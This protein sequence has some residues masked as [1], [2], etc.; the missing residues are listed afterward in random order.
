VNQVLTF[1]HGAV[2]AEAI[3][4]A[5]RTGLDLEELGRVLARSFGQSRMLERSLAR[6]LAGDLEAGA[7]LK[8]YGKDLGLIDRAAAGAGARLPL[9]VAAEGVLAEARARGLAEKDIAALV[10][11]FRGG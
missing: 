4:L 7:S 5:E 10:L 11:L 8:L 6:V 1:V 3:G 2:A 9:T